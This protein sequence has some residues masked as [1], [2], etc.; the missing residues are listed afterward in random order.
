MKKSKALFHHSSLLYQLNLD[1][2][3]AV[4]TDFLTN[5][6]SEKLRIMTY[7]VP[8][9]PLGLFQ[10][11]QYYLEEALGIKATLTV[12]S[13]WNC[14]PPDRN[15]IKDNEADLGKLDLE[16]FFMKLNDLSSVVVFRAIA[17]PQK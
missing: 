8:G 15:P 13:R 7:L 9:L 2:D 5:N 4:I 1:T 16:V 11:Y 14:P 12:E 17:R 10:T 3:S 6:M